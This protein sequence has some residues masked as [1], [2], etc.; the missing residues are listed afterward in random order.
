[1]CY[2]LGIDT[3]DP[4]SGFFGPAYDVAKRALRFETLR[5]CKVTDALAKVF[6]TLS[7]QPSASDC[8]AYTW[9]RASTRKI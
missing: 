3:P 5:I 9:W 1:M 2:D 4:L 8:C 7:T 6:V